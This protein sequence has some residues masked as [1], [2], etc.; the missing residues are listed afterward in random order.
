MEGLLEDWPQSLDIFGSVWLSVLGGAESTE[1]WSVCLNLL[2]HLCLD[3]LG[4]MDVLL[5]DRAVC[6][7]ILGSLVSEDPLMWVFHN[8]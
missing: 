2:E 1:E 6:F 8:C 4:H 7:D 3:L 5:E